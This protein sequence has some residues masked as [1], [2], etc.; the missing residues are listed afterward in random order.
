MACFQER[1]FR[2]FIALA[3]GLAAAVCWPRRSVDPVGKVRYYLSARFR[4]PRASAALGSVSYVVCRVA[5]GDRVERN[6]ASGIKGFD[7]SV[8]AREED[9]VAFDLM[10]LYCVVES[11]LSAED[12]TID[13]IAAAGRRALSG[14]NPYAERIRSYGGKYPVRADVAVIA[15]TVAGRFDVRRGRETVSETVPA[16]LLE[17]FSHCIAAYESDGRP[18]ARSLRSGRQSLRKFTGGADVALGAMDR[19]FISRYAS[20]LRE[21]VSPATVSFYLA[22]LRN[23]VNKAGSEGLLPGSF[24]WPEGCGPEA[25]EARGLSAG[26]PV[27]IP[28]LRRIERM[29]LSEFPL[30]D[31][32]RD[33]FMFG[34]YARGME[35]VDLACLK[36]SDVCREVLTYRRRGNGSSRAVPLGGKA[37]A[38]VAK[39]SGSDSEFLFP[40]LRRK[41][42]RSYAS[43]RAELGAALRGVGERLGLPVRLTFG[44][45]RCSWEALSKSANVAESLIS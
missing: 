24:Q 29:D 43:A 26:S 1:R 16:G 10:T 6:I 20:Y 17:Y 22:V 12:A 4:K 44:M 42:V 13:D 5:D 34:F 27:D 3:Y 39:Y 7:G 15:K 14:A 25:P 41:W 40:I 45:S 18:Y 37:M 11:S 38:I 30:L 32:A 23:V 19:Y 8:I 31:L 21:R 35:L 28:T 33:M 2:R 9:R 36:V